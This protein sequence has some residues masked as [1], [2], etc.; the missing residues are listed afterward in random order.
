MNAEEFCKTFNIAKEKMEYMEQE[1]LLKYLMAEDGG[2]TDDSYRICL[3]NTLMNIGMKPEDIIRY[4]DIPEEGYH[5][6]K[7]RILREHR[8]NLLED[9]H[10]KQKSL[11]CLDY[12]IHE[13]K[14]KKDTPDYS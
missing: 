10:Q 13:H 4:M 2:Y 3:V 14:K 6:V 12:F 5:D 1:G 11:D 8:K 9:I 7:I